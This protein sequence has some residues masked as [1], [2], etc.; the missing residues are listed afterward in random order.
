MKQITLETNERSIGFD[1]DGEKQSANY[2]WFRGDH[3]NF[4]PAQ[5]NMR[6]ETSVLR[7]VL[8]G[9]LPRKQHI[10]PETKVTAFGSCFAQNISRW[11]AS[12]NYSVLT[13]SGDSNSYVVRFGEGMV[14]TFVIRQQ[15]E[16]AFEG[17][18]YEEEL[19]HDYS[20]ES[21]GYDEE[22]RKETHGLFMETDIFILTL[23]LSEVWYDE[24]TGG[25]FWRAV[26]RDKYDSE[27][28]KFRVSTVA[29][30][31]ENLRV[32]YNLIRKHRPEARVIF[33]LSPIPLVATFRDASCITANS[34]SKAVLR[35][36]LDEF[37]REV[38]EPD[39]LY[40]WPSYEI[41]L[42]VFSDRWAADRRHVK[43]PILDFIMTLF[44]QY[45]CS[46]VEPR[47]TIAEA[48]INAR[49]SEGSLPCNVGEAFQDRDE[50]KL[51]Q[52]LKEIR[53]RNGEADAA[54]LLRRAGELGM[55]VGS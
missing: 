4:N 40:Y 13:K 1:V 48:W 11:L 28:H 46:G 25:V 44:E 36:A 52:A 3:C 50:E 45:W 38:A 54:L 24:K 35:A 20:A 49:V 17:T 47:H 33:T 43:Q 31:K 16:W 6:D 42:D 55:R 12:R 8:H 26:P 51:I 22:I 7:H 30:N 10:T 41:V 5:S 34:V 32:I 14:N 37:M 21:H 29:E 53:L 9:W 18:R 23:G 15:F 19:W 2:T 39:S 27:R